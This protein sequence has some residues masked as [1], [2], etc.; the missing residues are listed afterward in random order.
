MSS[1]TDTTPDGSEA[2][3]AAAHEDSR[4]YEHSEDSWYG[5]T[6]TEILLIGRACDVI[7]RAMM[8]MRGDDHLDVKEAED[9]MDGIDGILSGI[10]KHAESGNDSA[11]Q[12]LL[13][14]LESMVTH[15]RMFG[16]NGQSRV[17]WPHL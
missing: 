15:D 4:P 5:R 10:A 3:A 2:E 17:A 7:S 9:V 6:G 13:I 12:G 14:A 1:C 16:G 11:I 8:I